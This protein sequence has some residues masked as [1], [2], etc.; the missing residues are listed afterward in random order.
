MPTT[1]SRYRHQALAELDRLI[2]RAE[3]TRARCQAGGAGAGSVDAA[4]A[5]VL[6]GLADERLA[7]LRR[8]RTSLLADEDR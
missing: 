2:E 1:T 8:S 6:L 7:E 3:A 5:E 4:R